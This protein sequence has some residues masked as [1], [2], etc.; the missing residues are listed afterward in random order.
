MAKNSAACFRKPLH[1]S[2]FVVEFRA[3]LRVAV[4]RVRRGDENAADGDFQI[5][6]LCVGGIAGQLVARQH[7]LLA[8]PE[9]G[10]AIPRPLP[11][12]DGVI[13][14]LGDPPHGEIF[15]GALQFLKTG[16]IRLRPAQPS[17][18]AVETLVDVIDVESGDF[19]GRHES[20][21]TSRALARAWKLR[22]F[23]LLCRQIARP[24]FH[25]KPGLPL[26]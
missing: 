16:H 13:A 23:C 26:Q 21:L 5:A 22:D 10:D 25:M 1:P 24:I 12:P 8:A 7:R 15:I 2:E 3:G 17:E 4:R 14:S 19:H 11:P 6:A 20:Q 18:H 9:N